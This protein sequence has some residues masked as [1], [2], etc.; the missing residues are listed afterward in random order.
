MVL[1]FLKRSA[2]EKKQAG[3]KAGDAEAGPRP[4]TSH[5]TYSDNRPYHSHNPLALNPPNMLQSQAPVA[6]GR[7]TTT[8]FQAFVQTAPDPQPQSQQSR[9]TT[10]HGRLTRKSS[11]DNIFV[12]ASHQ[13]PPN[14]NVPA[15]INRRNPTP[16]QLARLAATVRPVSICSSLRSPVATAE[17][18]A[19]GGDVWHDA[20]TLSSLSGNSSDA[21]EEEVVVEICEVQAIAVAIKAKAKVVNVVVSPPHVKPLTIIVPRL[22]SP[23]ISGGKKKVVRNFSLPSARPES[24]TLPPAF[25]APLSLSKRM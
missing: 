8:S 25:P 15:R 16:A 17:A 19:A 13:T 1:N 24:P 5:S 23:P 14:T 20:A 18:S 7:P 9:P 2:H 21:E 11:F 6:D 12:E 10:A 3:N 4:S 22:T